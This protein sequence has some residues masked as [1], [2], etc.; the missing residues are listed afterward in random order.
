MSVRPTSRV[1]G[2]ANTAGSRLAEPSSAAIF[3][4]GGDRDPADLDVLGGGALEQL[5]RRVEAHQL[6]DRRRQQRRGRPAAACSWSGCSQQ[7]EQAV[8]ADVDRRL[9]PGVEQQDAG[10]DQLVLGEP[11]ALG[12]ADL[13]QVGEQVVARGARGARRP[14]RAGRRRTRRPRARRRPRLPSSGRTRTSSRSRWTTAAAAG[15]RRRARP[16][17]SAM[18]STGSCSAIPV[19]TSTGSVPP[20]RSTRPSTSRPA[21]SSTHGRSRSTC[22]RAN[23]VLIS[24]RSRVWSGGSISRIAL[25]WMRL[26]LPNRSAGS[27]SRQIRPSRRSRRTALASACVNASHRPQA[28]VPLHRR[29][30]P[31]P[32]ERRVR[33]GDDGGVGEVQRGAD[34]VTGEPRCAGRRPR[35]WGRAGCVVEC[36]ERDARGVRGRRSPAEDWC[37][38]CCPGTDAF[39]RREGLAHRGGLRRTSTGRCR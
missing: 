21:S 20:D 28:L 6:L 3:W 39:P 29:D 33:V 4:P 26:K 22:P 9:V 34:A 16:S 18:T 17:S 11:V 24:R 27:L 13:H 23:A 10:G 7:R 37:R 30:R 5:Q 38:R 35:P 19:R 15:G 31:G 1:S 8:A 14:A 36:W 32:G 25:R 12:V 2:S